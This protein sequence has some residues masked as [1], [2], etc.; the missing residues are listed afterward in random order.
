MRAPPAK[1]GARLLSLDGGGVKGISSLLILQAIMEDVKTIELE[2]GLSKSTEERRPKDYFDLACGT[3]TGGLICMLLFRLNMPV[4]EAI[5]AYRE[6]SGQVFKRTWWDSITSWLPSVASPKYS[7][8]PLKLAIKTL[9]GRYPLDEHDTEA[10]EA[11]KGKDDINVP[12]YHE[13]AGKM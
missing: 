11:S 6:L 13:K 12:L 7:D 5:K 1:P 4:S 10:F 2:Q 9:V 3:S 8:R